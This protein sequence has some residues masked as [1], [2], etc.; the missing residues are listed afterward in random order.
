MT[1]T[2][3]LQNLKK[4]LKETGKADYSSSDPKSWKKE[5]DGSTTITF[6][7][8]DWKLH[9]NFFGG[10]PYGGREV[11]FYK[12]RAL[13][14]FVYYGW[15]VPSSNNI[16]EIYDVLK[17][18]LKV[19]SPDTTFR[20]P[21]ELTHRKFTYRNSW[22]GNLEQFTGEE[23]IMENNRQVYKAKYMGGLVDQRKDEETSN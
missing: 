9:D 10:E 15:I 18:A 1:D 20:G 4:F 5:L 11:V 12:E 19:G 13:W 3:L 17:R 22:K 6:E 14:I 2:E 21:K 16:Q 8:G 23:I 7:S